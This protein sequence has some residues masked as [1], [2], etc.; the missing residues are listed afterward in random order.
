MCCSQSH[1][2]LPAPPQPSGR[3][4]VLSLPREVSRMG[5]AALSLHPGAPQLKPSSPPGSPGPWSGLHFLPVCSFHT[6]SPAEVGSSALLPRAPSGGATLCPVVQTP[7]PDGQRLSCWLALLQLFLL[8]PLCVGCQSHR[9]PDPVPL[10][11]TS[12]SM[13]THTGS[14]L[15]LLI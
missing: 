3:G 12:D 1:P 13:S 9:S 8:E 5:L 7:S 15:P 2:V 4:H 14:P 6:P 11:V 10:K